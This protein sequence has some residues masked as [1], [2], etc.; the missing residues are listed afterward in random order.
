MSD[1]RFTFNPPY[2]AKPSDQEI[3]ERDNSIQEAQVIDDSFQ[4]RKKEFAG[5]DP[6][7]HTS[8]FERNLSSKILSKEENSNQ[9]ID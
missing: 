1:R 3:E 9:L 8:E 4:A 5:S 2:K 7:S 6:K